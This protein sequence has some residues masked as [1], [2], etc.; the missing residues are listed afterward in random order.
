[1]RNYNSKQV[2]ETWKTDLLTSLTDLGFLIF[3]VLT[4]KV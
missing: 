2:S 3:Y 4:H 1:M